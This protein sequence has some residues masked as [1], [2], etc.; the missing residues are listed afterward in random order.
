MA[1]PSTQPQSMGVETRGP[2]RLEVLA[3]RVIPLNKEFSRSACLGVG[4][5]CV[6]ILPSC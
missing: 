3:A 4:A 1:L 6:C 5:V 2:Y